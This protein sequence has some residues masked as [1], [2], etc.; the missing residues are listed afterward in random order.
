MT[1]HEKLDKLLADKMIV[2]YVDF[3]IEFSNTTSG[4]SGGTNF[5]VTNFRTL[6]ITSKASN[7]NI[8]K[9]YADGSATVIEDRVASSNKTYDVSDA[10]SVSIGAWVNGIGGSCKARLV[11]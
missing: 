8:I 6:I 4:A 7:Y 2:D 9:R 10:V 11:K 5:D 3:T 1:V